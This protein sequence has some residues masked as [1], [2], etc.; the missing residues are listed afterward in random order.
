G[1]LLEES[2]RW[3]K[4]FEKDLA[5]FS[6]NRL[7]AFEKDCRSRLEKSGPSGTGGGSSGGGARGSSYKNSN[8]KDSCELCQICGRPEEEDQLNG[9]HM[10]VVYA[11]FQCSECDYT[12]SSYHGR[13]RP[14]GKLLMGQFCSKCKGRGEPTAWRVDPSRNL[15]D[16]SG[17][18]ARRGMH[19]SSLCEACTQYG[20]CMGI[21][22]DPLVL[23]TALGL[24]CESEVSWTSYSSDLPE[25]LV[26]SLG[27]HFRDHQVCLQPHVF[28]TSQ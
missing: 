19:Q 21:F 10:C 7:G 26:A 6:L 27:P 18:G 5:G 28:T 24:I 4:E 22:Y 3:K 11:N 8:S 12:W 20:N 1:V 13:V 14:G 15:W 25:L 23:T 17:G 2:G 16:E 9:E